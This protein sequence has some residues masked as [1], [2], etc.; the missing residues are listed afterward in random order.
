MEHESSLE[1]SMK[2]QSIPPPMRLWRF[3]NLIGGLVVVSLCSC[4]RPNVVELPRLPPPADAE[5][6][7][8]EPGRPGGVF[9]QTVVGDISTLNPLVSEDASSGSAISM[10]L[11]GMTTWNPVTEKVEPALAKSWEIGADQRTFTFHLREGLLWSDGVPLTTD[12]VIFSYRCYY[13][14]RFPTRTRFFISINGEPCRVEKIDNLTVRITAPDIFAPFLLFVSGVDILPKHKLLPSFEDGTLLE[15]WSIS[16]AK[17]APEQIVSSGPFVLHSFRPAERIVFARNPN[18]FKLDASGTRL[19]YIDFVISKLVKDSNASIVAFAQGETDAE[20]IT[21]DNVA[22]VARGEKAHDFT[23]INRGPAPGTGFIWFNQNPGAD[24]DGKPY[25]S[26][27]KLAWFRNLRFRQAISTAI[28]REGIIE[29]VLFGRGTPLYGSVSP[30]NTRWHNPEIVIFPYDPD[31]AR[32]LLR[33]EGFS[34]DDAGALVDREGYQ[35]S[36]FAHDQQRKR[37]P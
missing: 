23:I 11:T 13:D 27:E 30:A 8:Y 14:E 32:Q 5:I 26:P 16:T 22:W 25:V 17:N 20:G 19:P 9:I 21:P 35:V 1:K 7:Q 4:G 37:H 34:W 6:I 10:L 24:A 36:V 33:S 15:Q 29:G 2:Q 31:R 3:T 28:D 12:D 18:Y